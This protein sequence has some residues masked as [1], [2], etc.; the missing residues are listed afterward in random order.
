MRHLGANFFTQFRNKRLM[1]LFKRLCGTNQK[2]KFDVLWAKLDEITESEVKQRRGRASSSTDD[3]PEPLCA[4]RGVDPPNRRRRSSRQV[5]QHRF[6][7]CGLRNTVRTNTLCSQIKCFSHWIEKEPMERWSLLHDTHG[8]R[9]G[10]MTSNLVEVYNWV[11]RGSRGLPLVAIVESALHGTT[12]WFQERYTRAS[13]HIQNNP[14]TPYC[15]LTMAYMAEKSR[16][17]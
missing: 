4:L 16:K 13:L 14:T 17:G 1:N 7:V 8:A 9:Y 2:K 11:L 15:A 12:L 6:H 3:V 5:C 10:I